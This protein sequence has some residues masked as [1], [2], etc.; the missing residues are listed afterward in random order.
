MKEQISLKCL[1]EMNTDKFKAI[2][3]NSPLENMP[4]LIYMASRH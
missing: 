2:V 4:K 3:S 1:Q